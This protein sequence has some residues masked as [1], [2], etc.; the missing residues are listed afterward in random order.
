MLKNRQEGLVESSNEKHPVCDFL[1]C[2]STLHASERDTGNPL[3]ANE[4]PRGKTKGEKRRQF[5]VWLRNHVS[6]PLNYIFQT[7]YFL[8][9]KFK[10]W[11]IN[12]PSIAVP[13]RTVNA[14]IQDM[15]IAELE[16]YAEDAEVCIY[17]APMGNVPERY[18]DIEESVRILEDLLMF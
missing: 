14:K 4:E 15:S 12:K 16:R 3:Q 5:E 18:Y 11:P 10:Y 8:E 1:E 9:S 6:S 7:T 13:L 2:G 17:N